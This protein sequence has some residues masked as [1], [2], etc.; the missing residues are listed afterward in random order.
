MFSI[1]SHQGN[2]CKPNLTMKYYFTPTGVT[3]IK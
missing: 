3:K 2:K 1:V